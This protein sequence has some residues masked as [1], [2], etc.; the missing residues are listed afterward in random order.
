MQCFRNTTTICAQ[1]DR[2][3][4]GGLQVDA[5]SNQAVVEIAPAISERRSKPRIQ[6]AFP[7]RLKGVAVD[8]A[9]ISAVA[10]VDN[11]SA[12]GLYLRGQH[13]LRLNS[14][15]EVVVHLFVEEETGSTVETKGTVIRVETLDDGTH[16]MAMR[17]RQHRFL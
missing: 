14:E 15:L 6:E 11:M 12:G 3:V 16:G 8:G 9:N 5:P 1:S 17:I 2:T 7:A 10:V 13:Q 4:V